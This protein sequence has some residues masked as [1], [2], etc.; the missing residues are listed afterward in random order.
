MR[1]SLLLC[2]ALTLHAQLAQPTREEM[3]RLTPKNPFPRFEDGRPQAPAALLEKVRALGVDSVHEFLRAKG[4][5]NQFAGGFEILRPGVKLVGRAVTAQ[6]LPLR[7]DLAEAIEVSAARRRL[8][9][10]TN[11]KVI[12]QLRE[13]D[14]PVI[15]VM[16]AAPGHNFGGDN[17]HAAIYGATKTGAVI[18]GTI[19]DVEGMYEFPTQIYFRMAHPAAV[20]NVTVVG[21][22]I[23]IR[24]GRAAVLPGD[25]VLGDRT[26]VVFIPPHLLEEAAR[27][28]AK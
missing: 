4:Y 12:D 25:V 20:N 1:A 11:Q 5:P 28:P 14:V 26:G 23:P 19:R 3:I 22:N 17:L 8:A 9:K 7:P 16:G 27:L 24:I 13:G 21:I 10:S 6:Y 2:F 15:D 18:D